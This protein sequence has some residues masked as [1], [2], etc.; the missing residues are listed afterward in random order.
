MFAPEISLYDS[1][2]GEHT[3]RRP[4]CDHCAMRQ[5]DRTVGQPAEKADY[6]IDDA[7]RHPMRAKVAQHDFKADDLL[8]AEPG[9]RFVKQEKLWIAHHRHGDPKHLLGSI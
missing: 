5:R 6:V 2:V 1:I 4:L 3:A 9:G 7:Q 8:L